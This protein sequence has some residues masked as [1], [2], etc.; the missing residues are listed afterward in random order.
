LVVEVTTADHR[1]AHLAGT[2]SWVDDGAFIDPAKLALTTLT[3]MLRWHS[4]E[5]VLCFHVPCRVDISHRIIGFAV[6]VMETILRWVEA[7]HTRISSSI[8]YRGLSLER[9]TIQC[10][11]H[12]IYTVEVFSKRGAVGVFGVEG[13]DRD[14]VLLLE[15]GVRRDKC[16]Y[17]ESMPRSLGRSQSMENTFSNL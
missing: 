5:N 12:C 14:I 1:E 6:N 2:D 11:N 9:R 16:D 7:P 17:F 10:A 13:L 4:G 8:L 3:R 15:V